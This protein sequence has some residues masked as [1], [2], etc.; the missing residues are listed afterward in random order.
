MQKLSKGVETDKECV[1][2]GCHTNK[3]GPGLSI[4]PSTDPAIFDKQKC[5]IMQEKLITS[6][7]TAD[8]Q[9]MTHISKQQSVLQEH[10]AVLQSFI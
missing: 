6:S 3:Q 8:M 10:V 4:L 9:A 1:H 5:S 7:I 2:A